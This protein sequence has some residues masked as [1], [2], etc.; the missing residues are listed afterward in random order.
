M[1]SAIWATVLIVLGLA[2]TSCSSEIEIPARKDTISEKYPVSA[3]NKSMSEFLQSGP[4]ASVVET[5]KT[6]IKAE[7]RSHMIVPACYGLIARN[8]P[9]NLITTAD[10][11]GCKEVELKFWD[12]RLTSA[13]Q[14]LLER[15]EHDDE[16]NGDYSLYPVNLAANAARTQTMWLAYRDSMC[17]YEYSRFRG[18]T[19]GRVTGAAC[20]ARMTAERF[21]EVKR[22]LD[23][24][25]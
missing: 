19:L 2:S 14:L 22:M 16:Q 1:K 20:Q 17:G 3:T 15:L 11:V 6:C 24:A 8:C 12:A 4:D 23:E 9:E 25:S 10:M 13:Y 18:G 5:V 21:A 7:A